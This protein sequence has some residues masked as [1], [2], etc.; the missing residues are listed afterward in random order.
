MA[1]RVIAKGPIRKTGAVMRKSLRTPIKSS[2]KA[3]GKKY[4]FIKINDKI[5]FLKHLSV[6]LNAGIPLPDALQIMYEQAVTKSMK[7]LLETAIKDLSGGY[8]ISTSFA[9]FPMVFE[10]FVTNA[11]GVGEESGTLA[12]Q[13]AHVSQQLEKRHEL[14]SKVRAA[15]FYPMFVF[16]GALS[17]GAYLAFFLLPKLLPLFK[18][19]RVELPM[20]TKMLL[21]LGSILINYWPYM[22][23][24]MIAAIISGVVLYRIKSIK[25]LVHGIII[26]LPIVG[27]LLKQIEI[28]QFSRVLGTLLSGG[29]HIVPALRITAESM[30]N[31]IFMKTLNKMAEDVE[32]GKDLGNCMKE[33]ISLFS[34]TASSMV[35]I[36]EK[37]GKL[38]PSLVSLAD[39]TEKEADNMI[40]NLSTLIEPALLM[41]MG[42]VVG[43]VALAIVTP[44]YQLTQGVSMN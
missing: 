1:Q 29:T 44:I 16:V 30:T 18:S 8:Q 38:P 22:L 13:L 15:L 35:A 19:M 9:K 40:K 41:F 28:V 21:A 32:M 20:T 2:E 3:T 11:M 10:P 33:H 17:V 27:S 39:F 5:L 24:G 25:F 12:D 34:R 26:R 6:M 7:I 4:L 37:T 42:V 43:F 31:L 14:Q 36:G 23:V